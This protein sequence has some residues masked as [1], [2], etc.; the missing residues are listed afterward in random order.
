MSKTIA[1]HTEMQTVIGFRDEG[2][3]LVAD[4][5]NGTQVTHRNAAEV[6]NAVIDS[7][8]VLLREV[9]DG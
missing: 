5:P 2:G 9:K 1:Y 3:V 8:K 4:L 6:L 7:S